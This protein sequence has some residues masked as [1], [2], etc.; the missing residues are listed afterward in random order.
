MLTVNKILLPVDFHENSLAAGRQAT[1]LARHFHSELILLHVHALLNYRLASLEGGYVLSA[2]EM[3]IDTTGKERAMLDTFLDSELEGLTV[4]RE[5]LEGDPA[6]GIVQF[7]HTE[8]VDLIVMPTH[9]YGPF[10]RFILGS[11]TAKVLHDVECPVWTGAHLKEAPVEELFPLHNILCAL[12]LSSHS[13]RTLDW[14]AQAAAEFNA[15]LTLAH[16]SAPL[17]LTARAGSYFAP[18]WRG[19]LVSQ[20]K[21]EIT[22]LQHSVG[23]QAE[24]IIESGEAPKVVRQAAEQ[25]HADLL[26]IGR[27][28]TTGIT[29]RLRTNAYAIIRE[30]PCPVVS[31]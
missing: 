29:G 25:I 9:G 5:L 3:F 31:V 30:S 10:R 15:R 4:R 22:K 18:E 14:A 21:E 13:H 6:Q 20:A 2:Q 11:V 23:T 7:A 16:A 17:E 1:A 24:V 27:S 26:V 19:V 12:D 28:P 8:K